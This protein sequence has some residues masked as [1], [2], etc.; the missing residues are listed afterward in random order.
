MDD[1]DVRKLAKLARLRLSN[2]EVASIGPQ[3]DKIL[4]FVAKLS[5]VD[6]TD[7]VP[8]T[9]A[10]ETSNRLRADTV[11]EGLTREQALANAPSAD[12]SHFRVPSV[13]S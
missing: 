1:D 2:E 13:L 11:T 3:L 7:V 10:L 9:T 8:M 5:E 4:G 6:T 12:D